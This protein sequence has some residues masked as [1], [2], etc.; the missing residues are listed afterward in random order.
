MSGIKKNHANRVKHGISFTVAAQ[1]FL[2]PDAIEI[3]DRE[4]EGEQ[5]WQTIGFAGAILTVAHTLR[6]DEAHEVIRIISAR[7]ATPAERRIYEKAE[8]PD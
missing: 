1:V 8:T 7:K 5:R 6:D 4:V 3:Q 2:D